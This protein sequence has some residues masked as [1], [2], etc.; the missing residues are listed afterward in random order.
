MNFNP[1]FYLWAPLRKNN[2]I[3]NNNNDNN[4]NKNNNKRKLLVIGL[5]RGGTQVKHWLEMSHKLQETYNLRYIYTL[6]GNKKLKDVIYTQ[7]WKPVEVGHNISNN[8][9]VTESQF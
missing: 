8:E 1:K 2:N 9:K 7:N 4:N 3:D 5:L 6:K